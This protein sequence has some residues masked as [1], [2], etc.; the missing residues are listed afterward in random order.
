MAP[1]ATSNM[2]RADTS[3][4]PKM[5]SQASAKKSPSKVISNKK[6]SS[7][8]MDKSGQSHRKRAV[9]HSQKIVQI[10]LGEVEPEDIDEGS[11]PQAWVDPADAQVTDPD[12]LECVGEEHMPRK[13]ALPSEKSN[14]EMTRAPK[15]SVNSSALQI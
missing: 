1:V 12:D 10:D 15:I 4:T 11:D 2:N 13:D 9:I 3:Q 5:A 8:N 7:P 6:W 14:I